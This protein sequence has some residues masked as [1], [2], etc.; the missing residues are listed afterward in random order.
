MNNLIL[1]RSQLVEAQIVGTPAIGKRYQFTEIPN[2][3]KNNIVLYGLAAYSATQLA[4]SP[5]S[6]TVIAAAGVPSVVATLV[7]N[8][9]KEF[10]YQ[11]PMFNLIRSNVG[12]F[13][14]LL[15]PR[16]INLTDCYIQLA[17]TVGINADEVVV[18][19]LYYEFLE[20]VDPAT[21]ALIKDQI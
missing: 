6:N 12:G 8:R 9:K 16:V 2:L 13:V 15:L 4:V 20:N 18:F 19:S 17:N 14:Q 1:R 5:N 11:E 3:A 21:L 10:M 7:N